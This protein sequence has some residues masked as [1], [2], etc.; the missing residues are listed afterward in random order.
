MKPQEYKDPSIARTTADC[1][2]DKVTSAFLDNILDAK[3][4]ASFCRQGAKEYEEIGNVAKNF[5]TRHHKWLE[6][7]I[8]A[9]IEGKPEPQDPVEAINVNLL[10]EFKRWEIKNPQIKYILSERYVYSKT[11]DYVGTFDLLTEEEGQWVINDYKFANQLDIGY[12]LQ[13][14]AY[15]IALEEEFQFP[16][17]KGRILRFDKRKKTLNETVVVDLNPFKSVFLC[18]IPIVKYIDLKENLLRLEKLVI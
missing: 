15:A 7:Y 13:L 12:L 10:N 2:N 6:L 4:I 11:Y 8:K 3:L 17:R 1:I 9:K 14:A 5:G 18:L 16:V